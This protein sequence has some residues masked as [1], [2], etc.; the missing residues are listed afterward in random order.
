MQNCKV[1]R[2]ISFHPTA[3]AA[4][5]DHVH[6]RQVPRSKKLEVVTV[7]SNCLWRVVPYFNVPRSAVGHES[8]YEGSAY[9][10]SNDL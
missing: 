1:C 10:H 7:E 8:I 4:Y 9:T 5:C 3:A 2:P 6:Q